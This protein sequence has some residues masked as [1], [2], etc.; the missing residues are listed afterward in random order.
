M[1]IPPS[2]AI[3]AALV[4]ATSS[5]TLSSAEM[6]CICSGMKNHEY[7]DII[8]AL[9]CT[10]CNLDFCNLFRGPYP[11][12]NAIQATVTRTRISLSMNPVTVPRGRPGRTMRQRSSEG[13]ASLTR[14]RES[15][16]KGPGGRTGKRRARGISERVIVIDS[17]DDDD[18]KLKNDSIY[19]VRARC[20]AL[21]CVARSLGC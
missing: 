15:T 8:D 11:Y 3:L 21:R 19:G 2:C 9:F 12:T 13:G 20:V 10:N 16:K 18:L 6:C 17:A 14:G 4:L 1:I 7:W 5:S